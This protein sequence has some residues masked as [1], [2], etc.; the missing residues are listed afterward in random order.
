MARKTNSMRLLD[1]RKM[2]YEVYAFSADVHS[3]QG[4][5][6]ATGLSLEHVYKTLVVMRPSGRP[7]LAI[8]PGHCEAS[9]ECLAQAIDEKKLRM[10]TQREAEALTGLQVGGISA[11][12]LVNR[13]FDVY[14]DRRA[15]SLDRIVVSAGCRGINL[16]L[17]VE[18]LVQVTG[19][20][21]VG[22]T[23]PEEE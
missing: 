4:V 23:I 22:A 13:G 14:L 12:A 15:L 18:D 21:F 8:V 10:A 20:T 2:P 6:E 19:A 11:L 17:R 9:L 3:A 1:A 5:A 7:L 16:R